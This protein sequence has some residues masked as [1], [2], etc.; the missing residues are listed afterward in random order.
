MS[1][2][3]IL[4][5]IKLSLSLI[6]LCDCPA[7]IFHAQVA[8]D[9]SRRCFG[10]GKNA[11]TAVGGYTLLANRAE[12]ELSGLRLRGVPRYMGVAAGFSAAARGTLRN[13]LCR[14]DPSGRPVPPHPGPLPVREG[15]RRRRWKWVTVQ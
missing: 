13:P 6:T 4:P 15:D 7:W 5:L 1:Y 11:P 3:L 14:N 8:A 12:C 2:R 9:G 10:L